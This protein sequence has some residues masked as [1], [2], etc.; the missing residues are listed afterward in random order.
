V[1]F[2]P[3][4]LLPPFRT[5]HAC[6]LDNEG[7]WGMRIESALAVRRVNVGASCHVFEHGCLT[8]DTD[9]RPKGDITAILG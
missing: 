9:N 2:L 8:D 4:F 1:V 5:H 6:C 7:R 3:H